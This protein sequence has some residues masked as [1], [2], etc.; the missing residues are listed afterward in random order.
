V[1]A[2]HSE[3]L[4]WHVSFANVCECDE[5]DASLVD[6]NAEPEKLTL[7]FRTKWIVPLILPIIVDSPTISNKNLR[8]ALLAYGKKHSLTDSILQEARIEA[9]A[10]LFCVAEENVKYAEGMKSELEK[11][12]HVVE[13]MYTSR[14]ETLCN[15]EHLVIGEEM[16]CLKCATN[17]ILDRDKTR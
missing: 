1:I 2:R 9:K 13:L 6:V 17:G 15:V 16:L 5:F 14:K 11:D 10:Q 8:Q 3:H 7:P 4:G 12:G